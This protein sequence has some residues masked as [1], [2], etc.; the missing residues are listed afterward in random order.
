[1]NKYS[2][3]VVAAALALG[4]FG[5]IAD[6]KSPSTYTPQEAAKAKAD[7]AAA[8]EA[9]A[10]MTPEEKAAAK[11]ARK[12]QKLKQETKT[13]DVGNPPSGPQKA[14]AITKNAAATKSDPKALPD[15]KSKQEAMKQQ[16][17]KASGQ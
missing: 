10:K 1:M 5:A 13:E 3:V 12:E 16:E 9:W 7:R 15:T 2:V 17:K 11:K 8:K 14:D 6:D 4:S